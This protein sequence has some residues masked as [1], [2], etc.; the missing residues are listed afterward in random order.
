MWRPK[1]NFKVLRKEEGEGQ[2][3]RE[4]DCE[5]ESEDRGVVIP[6]RFHDDGHDGSP[7][8]ERTVYDKIPKSNEIESEFFILRPTLVKREF[9]PSENY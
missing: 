3:K 7:T 4:N 6:M 5:M 1:A 8:R 9:V 2:Y